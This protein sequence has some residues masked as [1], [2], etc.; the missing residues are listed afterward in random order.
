MLLIAISVN[1]EIWP[2]LSIVEL[3]I[4]SDRIVVA[5]FLNTKESDSKFLINDINNSNRKLDTLV[6]QN[7]EHYF[8][9]L[10]YFE[11]SDS[12]LMFLTN[13]QNDELTWS[14]LRLMK[15]DTI[16]S[17]VQNINPGKYAFGIPRDVN[18]WD[19]LKNNVVEV[20]K[21]I[22]YI[23]EIKKERDNRK[24]FKWIKKNSEELAISSIV[25]GSNKNIGWGSYGWDVFKWI[26][27]N[28]I[29]TDTWKASKLFRKIHFSEEK[30]WLGYTG[31][32]SDYNGTS[33]KT[34]QEINFLISES[35]N[36]KNSIVTRRQ[37]LTYLQLA[38]RKVY[39]NN[40]PIPEIEILNEQKERQKA[41]RD[42]ILPLIDTESL[43]TLA[44]Q[45]VRSM[46]NPMDGVLEH[47]IDLEALPMIIAY[48]TKEEAG[49]F[50][51]EMANFIV[52]NSTMEQ[53]NEIS[54]CDQK[55]FIDIYSFRV[56]TIKNN[57]SFW[58][59]K[60]YGK[61]DFVDKPIVEIRDTKT[62]L[63]VLSEIFTGSKLSKY[64]G[65]GQYIIIDNLDLSEGNYELQVRGKAGE[66]SQ[67]IWQT[68]SL[69][70]KMEKKKPDNN[71]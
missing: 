43:K 64:F 19:E 16:Y 9:D 47:R 5:T 50:K 44:F 29:G 7:L 2:T 37:A 15:N 46:S 65:D 56:D 55:I 62:D 71:R 41:I 69:P 12:I 48:Y 52:H 11:K 24:L 40:Y 18:S 58:I 70:F 63:V 17:P 32:L 3:A 30:E 21:R 25:N 36:Q 57:L 4:K 60:R 49:E 38:S 10:N 8:Y 59:R 34:Y 22:T 26:T 13:N 33:F 20:D 68:I 61:E 67:Y 14:G 31:L 39:E 45:V 51:S 1:A 35:L 66:H 42:Q 27:E 23:K 53:W 6:L 54:E 28:N